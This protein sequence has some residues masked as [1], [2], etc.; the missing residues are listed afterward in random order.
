VN[1]PVKMDDGLIRFFKGYR[2][3]H[4]D[5]RGPFKGGIRFHPKVDLG[6]VKSLAFWMSL[7]SSLLDI[8][9]GGGKGGIQL[10]PKELSQNEL[11]TLTRSYVR[12]IHQN[13]GPHTDVPAPDVY[14]NP[15]IMAWIMD[16]YSKITGHN[17]PAVVTGKPVEIGG[18]LGRDIATGQGAFF[19]LENISR[20]LGL[21]KNKIKIAVNGFG[22][23]GSNFAKIAAAAGYK[24]VAV[25]DSKGGVYDENGLNIEEV[26][27]HKKVNG[28]LK[29]LPKAK[30]ISNE[31][32]LALPVEVLV[33]AALEGV[34]NENNC[35]NIKAQVILEVANGPVTSEADSY[36]VKK[37]A[38]IVPD[39]LAN[40]GGVV[41]SYF[42]WVQNIRHYYW[43]K[44]KVEQRLYEKINKASDEVWEKKE[45]YSCDLRTA[46]YMIA[47]ERIRKAIEYRGA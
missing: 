33:P 10:N 6:E 31:E 38:V 17:E 45:K 7:K 27:E 4:S 42:E 2:V 21:E 23:A 22:N 41:V 1:I 13:I 47:I 18:S 46:A 28:S 39:I 8:P 34:I 29:D 43:D 37:G 14:T 15:Q 24:I 3:Q 32:L 25:S 35:K 44:E 9:F 40:A 20:K 12:L 11:E 16:E 5:V 19:T 36:L 30:N 26:I